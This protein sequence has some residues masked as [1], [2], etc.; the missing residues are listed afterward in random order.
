MLKSINKDNLKEIVR[1]LNV[2]WNMKKSLENTVI[3]T[4]P[5]NRNQLDFETKG[6]I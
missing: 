6:Q 4:K 2:G 1:H 5:F 3:L